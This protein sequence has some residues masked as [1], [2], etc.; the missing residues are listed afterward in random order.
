MIACLRNVFHTERWLHTASGVTQ[1]S[2]QAVL[3]VLYG[4]GALSSLMRETNVKP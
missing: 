4:T 2:A 3:F 1:A